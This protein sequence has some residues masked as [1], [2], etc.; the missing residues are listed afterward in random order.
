MIRFLIPGLAVLW[1]V[2]AGYSVAIVSPDSL[3][4]MTPQQQY[5]AI[6]KAYHKLNNT[7]AADSLIRTLDRF[8]RQNGTDLDLLTLKITHLLYEHP[9]PAY[10]QDYLPKMKALLQEAQKRD[11]SFLVAKCHEAM[12]KHHFLITKRYE[13]AF[14][15]FT[16]L[17]ELIDGLS[18]PEFPGY[19]YA[20]YEVAS[21]YYEFFDYE[22]TINY[23]RALRHD[24]LRDQYGS[25]IFNAD[26]LG[27]AH[28]KLQQYDSAR[29]YFDWALHQLPAKNIPNEGWKGILT[30]NVGLTYFEQKN[31]ARAL[32][33]LEQGLALTQ[34]HELWDNYPLFGAKLALIYL[35][36]GQVNQALSLALSS[37]QAAKK[38]NPIPN[39]VGIARFVTE[40]YQ[41][42][43]ACYR[44]LG[45]YK[46]TGE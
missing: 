15:H 30:G 45:N 3:L 2:S 10:K 4:T 17:F 11:N 27:M 20:I 40:P 32:P 18:E 38:A 26:L 44:A 6:F 39:P 25:H 29:Y 34:Q 9:D 14:I 22:N 24:A 7:P 36:R 43:S 19:N 8:F 1:F 5:L 23:G 33:Y 12:G 21:A 28:L 31:Y 41:V 16:Q 13:D 37:L 46:V 35:D 42:L